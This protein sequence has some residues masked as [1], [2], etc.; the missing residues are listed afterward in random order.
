[1]PKEKEFTYIDALKLLGNYSGNQPYYSK[2]TEP[3]VRFLKGAWNRKN[4]DAVEILL[5][6]H[7]PYGLKEGKYSLNDNLSEQE[8]IKNLLTDL[9]Q[10]LLASKTLINTE[11]ALA[12][13]IDTIQIKSKLVII[14]LHEV[15]K[16][17]KTN[18]SK[19]QQNNKFNEKNPDF[20][21]SDAIEL[22]TQYSYNQPYYSKGAEPIVRFFKGA[23]NRK[24]IDAVQTVLKA[25]DPY[26]L[27]EGKTFAH[28]ISEEEK[29]NDL[30][31][32]LKQELIQE[33]KEIN[34]KGALAKSIEKIQHHITA[35][36][37][38]FDDL[39]AEIKNNSLKAQF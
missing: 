38:D 21:Y 35:R 23:W 4:I 19:Y 37:I 8:K 26:G 29:I 6:S 22:L 33:G 7:D 1:M 39:N 31:S 5:K 2:G 20:S 14:N 34:P 16:V 9:K 24:N 13:C 28:N 32:D 10:Q 11:G 12:R 3:I 25:H 17:I 27:I 18:N 15:N 36:T 30:L